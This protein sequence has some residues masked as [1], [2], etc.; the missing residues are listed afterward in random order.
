MINGSATG[1]CDFNGMAIRC[2]YAMEGIDFGPSD[3]YEI[4]FQYK[5]TDPRRRPVK[6]YLAAILNDSTGRF[7]LSNQ[8]LSILGIDHL[9]LHSMIEKRHSA[10]RHH[11]YSGIG[12]HLQYLDSFI[13]EK[14]MLHFVRKNEVCLPIHDSFV[15]R[16]D[17]LDEVEQV[18]KAY[19]QKTLRSVAQTKT[20]DWIVDWQLPDDS[21][22]TDV[23]TDRI[24]LLIQNY[25]FALCYL[26]SWKSKIYTPET[27]A[28][29]E[30]SVT[31][32]KPSIK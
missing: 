11:F 2:L 17:L 13:A 20:T 9:T 5:V 16:A 6:T 18:M 32:T 26:G 19:F 7:R 23:G 15:I 10:I 31:I 29:M 22:A 4:G 30:R 3:P 1:E 24:D 21:T 25:S 8:D 27:L 12:L 28:A 14:V